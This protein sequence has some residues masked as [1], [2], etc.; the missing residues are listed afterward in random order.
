MGHLEYAESVDLS[1]ATAIQRCTQPIASIECSC[2]ST[3]PESHQHCI[4]VKSKVAGESKCVL[5]WGATKNRATVSILLVDPMGNIA[6]AC[7]NPISFHYSSVEFIEAYAFQLAIRLAFIYGSL[8]M[9]LVE[10]ASR[11]IASPLFLKYC[12]LWRSRGIFVAFPST[13]LG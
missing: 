12:L 3:P 9:V 4:C 2:L 7:S 5:W 10:L 6:V 1:I 13:F 11:M 8:F